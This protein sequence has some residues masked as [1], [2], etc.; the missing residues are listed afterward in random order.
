MSEVYDVVWFGNYGNGNFTGG[1]MFADKERAISYCYSKNHQ[2]RANWGRREDVVC[3]PKGVEWIDL[4]NCYA[5]VE[6]ELKV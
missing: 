6:R 4:I 1:K 5:V 2:W 3:L